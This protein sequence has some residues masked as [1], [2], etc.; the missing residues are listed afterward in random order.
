[1][2]VI[3]NVDEKVLVIIESLKEGYSKNDFY[4]AFIR[5][6]PDDYKKLRVKYLAEER[7]AKGGK[8]HPMQSP[9]IYI[10]HALRS[11]LAERIEG[12]KRRC[13]RLTSEIF[14]FVKIHYYRSKTLFL[15]YRSSFISKLISDAP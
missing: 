14:F 12:K 10:K 9:E 5:E 11:Y 1:M 2:S 6:Y 4:D 13:P 7:Q 3:L 15:I 8:T